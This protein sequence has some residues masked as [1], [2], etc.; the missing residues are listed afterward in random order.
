MGK[1]SWTKGV[2]AQLPKTGFAP[3][4]FT[5][6]PPRPARVAFADTGLWL[7]IPRLGVMAPIVGVPTDTPDAVT[8]LYDQVGYLQ[9]TTFPTWKGHTVLT[10]H[11]YLPTGA[12]GPF[13]ALNQLRWGDIVRIHFGGQV[14]EYEVRRAAVVASDA[15]WV[16]K[17]PSS[18]GTWL[19]LIT[20]RNFDERTG[21]YRFRVAVQ[22]VLMRVYPAP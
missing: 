17:A 9:S 11:N 21:E 5:P 8:W 19:T 3:G 12:P 22:A 6:L 15:V 2:V 16:F 4:R 1:P 20:C 14:Y 18:R 10:A 7:E 13:A